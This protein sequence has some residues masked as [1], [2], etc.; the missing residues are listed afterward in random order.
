MTDLFDVAGLPLPPIPTK[1]PKKAKKPSPAALA[2]SGRLG[3][4]RRSPAPVRD[5]VGPTRD[6]LLGAVLAFPLH[7]NG[8][9]VAE[10][11]ERLPHGYAA[12][13][14][15]ACARETAE[16]HR[17]LI[18]QGIPKQS[19]WLCARTLL[20]HAVIKRIDDAHKE[21]GVL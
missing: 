6:L 10:V 1:P 16:L 2:A 12:D 3:G 9:L 19:A 17:K 13:L 15:K 4:A 8:R 5:R 18:S 21:A 20:H 11:T 7:V 14:N